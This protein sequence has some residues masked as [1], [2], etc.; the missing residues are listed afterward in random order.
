M[1]FV[2]HT[3]A[4]PTAV[5]PRL[6]SMLA[7]IDPNLPLSRVQTLD[8][9]VGENVASRRFLMVL[10]TG[11]A[12]VALLLALAGIYGVLSYTVARRRSEIGM[13]L[14]LGASRTHV[15]RLILGQGMR[16]V[17]LG[18]LLG[19]GVA[20]ALTRVMTTLLFDVTPADTTTYI[21]VIFVLLATAAL[22]CYL[23]AHSAVRLN[24]ISALREE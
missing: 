9:M 7:E 24:V 6:R 3:N 2:L 12:A 10:L 5:V 8:E 11:F 19:L 16:P 18:L 20:L 22:S 23:P 17:L 1:Q 4:P 21:A 13:R 14:A 15:L